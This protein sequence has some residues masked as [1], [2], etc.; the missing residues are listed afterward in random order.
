MNDYSG[1]FKDPHIGFKRCSNW[2][3]GILEGLFKGSQGNKSTE[4]DGKLELIWDDS[5]TRHLKTIEHSDLPSS[6]S[7]S[8]NPSSWD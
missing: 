2:I 7:H 4:I 8:I 3:C 1:E 6:W 5:P